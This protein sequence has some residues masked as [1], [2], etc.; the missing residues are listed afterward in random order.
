MHLLHKKVRAANVTPTTITTNFYF[1]NKIEKSQNNLWGPGKW[2]EDEMIVAS[3]KGAV[4]LTQVF[5][6]QERFSR[7]M[8]FP[9]SWTVATFQDSVRNAY[10]T[11]TGKSGQSV[12]ISF[13]KLDAFLKV[14]GLSFELLRGENLT[15]KLMESVPSFFWNG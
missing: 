10:G 1:V 2:T 4:D 15:S 14:F 7:D 6:D 11:D 12:F 9:D 13:E 3:E 8:V 5:P